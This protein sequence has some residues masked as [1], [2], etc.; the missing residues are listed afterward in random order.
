MA[1][2]GVATACWGSSGWRFR[3]APQGS[4]KSLFFKI[5]TYSPLVQCLRGVRLWLLYDGVVEAYT[6][7]QP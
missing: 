5:Q 3:V 7:V 4:E 6:R 1:L 2:S